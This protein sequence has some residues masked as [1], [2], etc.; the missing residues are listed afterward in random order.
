MNY[1]KHERWSE[2]L[3][4]DKI[5]LVL[6]IRQNCS[7]KGLDESRNEV[8]TIE[9]PAF[10]RSRHLILS[11]FKKRSGKNLSNGMVVVMEDPR[12]MIAAVKIEDPRCMGLRNGVT[13][14]IEDF[15]CKSLSNDMATEMED[16][17]CRGV[18]IEMEDPRCKSMFRSW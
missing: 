16:P 18:A 13:I 5:T 17:R 10:R 1:E 9:Q 14:E 3:V 15:R 8:F 6:R 2:L 12:C 4:P 7:V 11:S